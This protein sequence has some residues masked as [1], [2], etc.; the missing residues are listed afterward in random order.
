MQP[1]E[2]LEFTVKRVLA[3]IAACA[4]VVPVA[5]APAAQAAPPSKRLVKS[6]SAKYNEVRERHGKRAPGRNIVKYGVIVTKWGDTRP[7]KR[8]EVRKSVRQL[9]TLLSVPD[10]APGL[11]RTAV[12][13]QQQPS[14][15]QSP[16]TTGTYAGGYTIP[17]EIVMCESGGNPQAVNP[18]NPNRPAGLYQIITSTWLANGGGEFAPT[19]DA[20]TPEQQGIVA[21]RIYNGGAGRGQWAC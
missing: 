20:A 9:K 1:D 15:V 21:A 10:E 2:S 14:G 4:V 8:W 19:A 5:T 3:A 6:Y 12:E 17:T 18:S 11:V 13:P 7:A 16:G